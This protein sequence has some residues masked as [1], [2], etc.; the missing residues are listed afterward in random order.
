MSELKWTE[1]INEKELSDATDGEM[2]AIEVESSE[3]DLLAINLVRDPNQPAG[4]LAF[5]NRCSHD[6]EPLDEGDTDLAHCAVACPRH[7]AEFNMKT[8]AVLSMPA[9]ESIAA[10][11]IKVEN[12]SIWLKI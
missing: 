2:V 1:I 5:E 12:G 9:S 6:G 3:G 4:W 7:G 10:Y 11:E 8:G